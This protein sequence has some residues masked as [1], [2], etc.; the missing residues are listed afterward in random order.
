[1][2]HVPNANDLSGTTWRKSTHSN[3][4]GSCVEMA[5]LSTDEV[6]FRNSRFVTGPALVFSSADVA[7]FLRAVKSGEFDDLVSRW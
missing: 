7:T 3:P 5:R 6:A 4:S 1:M 2:D